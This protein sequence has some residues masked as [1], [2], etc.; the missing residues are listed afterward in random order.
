MKY[1]AVNYLAQGLSR[2]TRGGMC[3]AEDTG[4]GH[5]LWV[6]IHDEIVVQAPEDQS[7][8]VQEQAGRNHVHHLVGLD[9][10]AE[11]IVLGKRW[12]KA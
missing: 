10:P 12:R 7:E 3:R 6:P 11:G 2:R 9:H 1:K 8:E 5:L 4:L